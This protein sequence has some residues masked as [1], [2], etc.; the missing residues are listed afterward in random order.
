MA[1]PG[2]PPEKGED[3]KWEVVDGS[4]AGQRVGATS[5]QD[6]DGDQPRCRTGP[7]AFYII[8][9]ISSCDNDLN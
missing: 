7:P 2:A 8:I 1:A 6:R 5:A 9:L 3:W 4:A